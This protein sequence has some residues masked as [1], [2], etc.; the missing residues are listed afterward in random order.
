MVLLEAGHTPSHVYFPTDCVVSL[1]S[2]LKDGA[3]TEVAVVGNDGMLGAWQIMGPRAT[4]NRAV[5]QSTGWAYR[6]P[7]R[8]LSI[9]F[10]RNGEMLRLVLRYMQTLII[11]MAQTAI[12]NRHHTIEQQLCRRL[13][14]SLDRLPSKNL[15]MTHELMGDMLGVRREGVTLAARR[16]QKRG[17]IHYRRGQMTVLDRP[18][19][20]RLSCECYCAVKTA[21]EHVLP[22]ASRATKAATSVGTALPQEIG[23]QL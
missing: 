6:L 22:I 20:E 17:V 7:A 14:L 19:L 16:L 2:V 1:L 15:T 4:T 10:T 9:E 8:K 23:L 21:A 12:C 3:S 5:V 13:L 18:A 11:Q